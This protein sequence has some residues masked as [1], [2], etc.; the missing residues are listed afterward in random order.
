MTARSNDE[1]EGREAVRRRRVRSAS[2]LRICSA[3]SQAAVEHVAAKMSTPESSVVDLLSSPPLTEGN[4]LQI[5]SS[6]NAAQGLGYLDSDS[7]L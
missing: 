1:R 6:C 7:L 2:R 3:H 4:L 5:G